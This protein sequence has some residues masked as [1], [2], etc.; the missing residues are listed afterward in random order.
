[1][2]TNVWRFL[3]GC[4]TADKPRTL[5]C[6][7]ELIASA[8]AGQPNTTFGVHHEER[9]YTYQ[10]RTEW[11]ALAMAAVKYPNDPRWLVL[12]LAPSGAVWELYPKG[13]AESLARVSADVGFTNL[14]AIGDAAY[15]C[16]MGRLCFRREASGQWINLSAPWPHIDEGVIGFTAMAGASSELFYA[17][18]WG[19]EIWARIGS[20]WERQDS[21]TNQ[22]L[23]AIAIAA[24]GTAYCVGDNGAMLKGS[25]GVWEVIDTG[26]DANLLDVCIHAGQVF[27]CSD[28]EVMRLGD[29]GLTADFAGGTD[30]VPGTCLKLIPAGDEYLYSVGP[31][32]VFMRTTLGW[33]RL[34]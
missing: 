24:D 34:A 9:W 13:P 14:A 4:V 17:V 31:H 2:D 26:V 23:N 25:R 27:V 28:F 29:D 6:A 15:A 20:V 7:V 18:G 33:E 5:F 21:P 32:D 30:D 1:M 11:S 12:G 8:D 19:G 3:S 16:G 22:N 10:T